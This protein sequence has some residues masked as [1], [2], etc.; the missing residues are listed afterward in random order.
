[1]TSHDPRLNGEFISREHVMV[2]RSRDRLQGTITGDAILRDPVTG[3]IKL[4]GE[5]YA[6]LKGTAIAGVLVAK[7][8][9]GA[10]I[11]RSQAMARATPAP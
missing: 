4:R 11:R 5:I 3:A 8:A 6:V 1:M 9:D 10:A 2:N 7:L